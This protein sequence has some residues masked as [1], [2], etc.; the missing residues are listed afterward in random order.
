VI[1]GDPAGFAIDGPKEPEDGG[2]AADAG[3]GRACISGG[4]VVD[5]LGVTW[6]EVCGGD[7]SMGSPESDA[8]SYDDER[9]QHRVH[10]EG[11]L[12]QETEMTRGHRARIE[13]TTTPSAEE[14][15]LPVSGVTWDEARRLC[16]RAGGRLPF[17]AEWEYA[18]RAGTTTRFFWGDADDLKIAGEH[19]WFGTNTGVDPK[20]VGTRRPN[21]WG[22]E[23]MAGN[24]LEWTAD[25][26]E[27]RRYHEQAET[28][29][30]TGRPFVIEVTS[31]CSRPGVARVLR[32]G[33]FVG[34]P[35]WLRSAFRGGGVP[36]VRDDFIGFRCVRSLRQPGP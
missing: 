4:K 14:A 20:P 9:P 3:T 15:E 34:D 17:E 26:Y 8:L 6:I 32:G 13:G 29:K 36:V 27:A 5:E 28:A 25:C 23:D 21:A 11:F 31:P 33:S 12:I 19:A 1:D 2:S 22:L 35:R 18:A 24:V 30:R 10:V 16:E 7:F